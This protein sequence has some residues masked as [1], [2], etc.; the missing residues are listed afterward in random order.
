VE[1]FWAG[2]PRPELAEGLE[3]FAPLIG[4]WSL[5]VEEFEPDGSS[6]TTDAE[7]EFGWAL[8]GRAVADV[9]LSPSRTARAAGAPDGEWGVSIRFPD[10]HAD[11][12]RSTWLG[13]HRGWVIPFTAGPG[14]PGSGDAIVLAGERD[15]VRLRW[16]FS[17]LTADSFRWRAEE[18]PPGGAPWI[19]QRFTAS[20]AV[21]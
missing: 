18:T 8:D 15:G 16:A 3:L 13:P 2:E 14:E 6:T 20:R 1:L 4:R 10:P 11:T 7:W 9:W 12:W 21:F 19:R 5:V 17:E